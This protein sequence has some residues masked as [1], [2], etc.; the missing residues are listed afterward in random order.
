MKEE[1]MMILSML[2]EGKITAEDAIKLMEALEDMETPKNH[3]KSKEE[4]Y[5]DS[6]EE[7]SS[8][9]IFNTLE[10]IG[11]DISNVLSNMF[12]G[13]KDVGNSFIFR[14]NYE[15][16]TTDLNLDISDMNLPKLDLKTVN[17]SILLKPTIN[18]NLFIK[19]TCQYKK[20]LFSPDEPYFDFS[21]NENII[22][23]NPKYNSNISIK[24]D[25]SLPRKHYDEIILN[26]SNGK[27]DIQELNTDI[28]KCITTNSSINIVKLNS[29]EIDLTTKN[30]KIECKDISSNIIKSFTTNSSIFLTDLRSLE[31][32][33]KTANGKIVVS[34]IDAQKIIL[35]TSNALIE[36]EDINCDMIH[37]TTSNGKIICNDI[38]MNRAKEV[39]LMTS[40][41]SISSKVYGT[42]RDSYF[43]LETSMG[44]ISLEIPNLVYK[45]NNQAN[46]GFKK[47]VA[48]SI[49]FDEDKENIKFIVSTSNGSINIY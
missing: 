13:L 12:D 1:K 47:I 2:E 24:L 15:T 49:Y 34:D 38:D 26:S 45:I 41:G 21:A 20:G 7:K 5:D 32:E 8:K 9:P 23:F 10:D 35:K 14:N 42:N 3:N 31:I 36:T 30:G 46:L 19:V 11:S 28:L 29:K 22:T 37:L 25:V 27:I 16:I 17:G 44:N 18:D 33:A 48:H 6:Q 39:R 43:D 40:N 4:T